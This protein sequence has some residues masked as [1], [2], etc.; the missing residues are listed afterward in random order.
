MLKAI[1]QVS[2]V[3]VIML[4]ARGED[5]GSGPRT[6]A[7]RRRLRGETLQ[8]PG[9]DGAHQGRAPP[10]RAATTGPGLARLRGGRARHPLPEPRGDGGGEQVKLTPVEYKLLYHLV[11]NAGHLLPHQALLD[12][13]WGGD[14]DASPEYLKVFISRLRTKLRRAERAGL[15][16]DRARTRLP[17]RPSTTNLNARTNSDRG[18]LM[19]RTIVVPLDGSALAERALPYAVALCTARQCQLTLLRVALGN[20]PMT[21]DGSDWERDQLAAVDGAQAYLDAIKATLSQ[22]IEIATA[23]PYG[24]ADRQILA[25]LRR[26]ETDTVVM[27]THGRTGLAHLLHGSVAEAILAGSHVPVVLVHAQPAA[28]EPPVFDA[29]APRILVPLDGSALSEAAVPVALDY[30]ANS[31]ASAVVLV[32]VVAEPGEVQRDQNGRVLAY[33]DQQEAARTHEAREYLA[34][35]VRQAHTRAPGLG[36]SIDVRTGVQGEVIPQLAAEHR[37]DLI[38]MSTHA[39]T[40]LDRARVGSIAGSVLRATD[41]PVLLVRPEQGAPT[42]AAAVGP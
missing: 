40:G 22:T 30:A 18:R 4:T 19:T 42:P 41:R 33:V 20:A 28:A 13:V 24:P 11:R 14:Y 37:V 9:T 10:S 8:P 17:L 5:V 15:H 2:D 3:P 1:R 31:P 16:R 38:V 26:F 27:A 6:R 39:R 7:R 21:I 23:V 29:S 12:R 32:C 36:V 35:F 25:A 34:Y